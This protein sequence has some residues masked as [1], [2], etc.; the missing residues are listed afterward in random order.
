MTIWVLK[1]RL[2]FKIEQEIFFPLYIYFQED[3]F[4]TKFPCLL[5]K[6]FI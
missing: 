3:F 5:Q 6:L 4:L 1:R 2:K